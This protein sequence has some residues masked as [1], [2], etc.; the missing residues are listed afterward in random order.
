MQGDGRAFCAIMWGLFPDKIPIKD[1]DPKNRA[2]NFEL[3]FSVAEEKGQE[4]FLDVE[5]CVEVPYPDSLSVMT[6]IFELQRR[7]KNVKKA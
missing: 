5:D 7:F 2:F 6:Y 3:A 4:R 1:L